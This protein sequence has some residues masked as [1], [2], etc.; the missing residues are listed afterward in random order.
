MKIV[1]KN[2]KNENYDLLVYLRT[3]DD[4]NVHAEFA[5]MDTYQYII[6][7]L[8]EGDNSIPVFMDIAKEEKKEI[9]NLPLVLVFYLDREL[10]SNAQIIN[11]FAE[12]VND[13]IALRDA[14][15]MA[16]FLPTDGP[17]RIDCINPQLATSEEKSRISKMIMEIENSFDIGQGADDNLDDNDD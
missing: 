13:A 17:E 5:T 10:M 1:V 15:A 2:I 16:F 11:P 8:T 9:N 14:N 12:A 3:D 4:V 6:K 7:E